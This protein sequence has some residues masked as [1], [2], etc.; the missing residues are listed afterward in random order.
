MF[1]IYPLNIFR[2]KKYCVSNKFECDWKT[3]MRNLKKNVQ[4]KDYF[5]KSINQSCLFYFSIVFISNPFMGYTNVQK[6][7]LQIPITSNLKMA[8]Y[9]VHFLNCLGVVWD[10]INFYK[11]FKFQ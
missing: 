11:L 10:I 5:F 9:F 6:Q 4:N 8:R 3:Y 2:V 7:K 1:R